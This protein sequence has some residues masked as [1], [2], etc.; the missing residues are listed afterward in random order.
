MEAVIGAVGAALGDISPTG[1][2]ESIRLDGDTVKVVVNT[3]EQQLP[4]S[5]T[6]MEPSSY[7]R[8]GCLILCDEERLSCKLS[9]ASERFQDAAALSAVLAKICQLLD[10]PIDEDALRAADGKPNDGTGMEQDG[11]DEAMSEDGSGYAD[12]DDD[13]DDYGG[14]DEDEQE[15]KELLVE[16]GQR[17]GRWARH[18]EELER[19]CSSAQVLSMEQ[20]KASRQQIFSS[21]EGFNM[22]QN[23]LLGFIRRQYSGAMH[24]SADSVGDDVYTWSVEMWKS[25]FRPD[26]QLAK[27]LQEVSAK[28]AVSSIQLRFSFMRGLHP[29]YPPR[30][31]VVRPHL[32]A[33][34]PGA[35]AS[36]P[37]LTLDHWD[38]CMNMSQLLERIKEFLE[39]WGSVDVGH[40][41]NSTAAHPDSA[42][43]PVQVALARLE[44]LTD[45][46]PAAYYQH[47]DLYEA[48]STRGRSDTPTDPPQQMKKQK[49]D[50]AA[51]AAAA[52]AAGAAAAAAAPAAAAG[53]AAGAGAAAAGAPGQAVVWAKGT[54]YGYGASRAPGNL[55]DPKKAAAAQEAQDEQLCGL[56]QGLAAALNEELGGCPEAADAA[57]AA[58]QPSSSSSAAAAA[59]AADS[60]PMDVGLSPRQQECLAAVQGSVL[61]PLLVREFGQVAFPE[62]VSR[63]QYFRPLLDVLA[64]LCRPATE[65]M[66]AAHALAVP[67]QQQQAAAGSSQQQQQQQQQV[68]I[69][70][71]LRGLIKGATMYRER[72]AKTLQSH[73]KDAGKQASSSAVPPRVDKQ[74]EALL[75][76]A[77]RSME[78]ADQLLSIT[79]KLQH[80]TT[81]EEVA[82]A[83]AAAGDAGGSG[84]AAAAAAQRGGRTRRA[85]RSS[86]AAAVAAAEAPQQQQ[87][88]APAGAGG[89]SSSSA[90]YE[91]ALKGLVL[92]GAPLASRH[93][94][95]DEASKDPTG[96]K[97]RVQKV[98]SEMAGIERLIDV[99][100][101]SS[102]FVRV[103]DDNTFLWKALITGPEDTPYGGGC[104]VFDMFFPPNYPNAPP[105][106][107][108]VTTGNGSV[109]FNP[110]LYN[111]GKVCLSLLGTWNGGQGEGWN[112]DV[113]SAFQVLVS[114]QSLILVPEPYFNEPGYEQRGTSQQ[115][116]EYNKVIREATIRWAMIDQLRNPPAEFAA[117]IR[118]H[119]KLQGPA[120]L[121]QVQ[122]WI[123]EAGGS[124][125]NNLKALKGQLETELAKLA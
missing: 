9:A 26:C 76:E 59:A 100:P 99:S 87:G 115:S 67:L 72:M 43:S 7:P 15:D 66:L 44:A 91:A 5:I 106:V 68:S 114:I 123:D 46:K 88:A 113:S 1:Q 62:M 94:F 103:D 36:H 17:Q 58:G 83:A 75:A 45:V 69:V 51:P 39:E 24:V 41:G 90:A 65:Q 50:E 121:G 56:L 64:A 89:S 95:R 74:T 40:P 28:W 79:T 63:P 119:F 20:G 96:L 13:D 92:D 8:S 52:P 101:A 47:A 108:L 19:S 33:P 102:I 104:F 32:A 82:A 25:A 22:L 120:V 80:L 124:H 12:D 93:K 73:E 116:K 34:L 31:E 77:K 105:K 38:S 70:G 23:E 27:D 122:G 61:L 60:D 78:I 16:C 53:A 71:A 11:S 21:K 3:G 57:A 30:L 2:L 86:A 85:T 84:A 35:L 6:Y 117:V 97:A 49:T 107:N 29:F 14:G 125:A 4:V 112:P 37:L 10:I 109:R 55:W 54:G 48:R 110:N 18:E 81:A 111:C 42:F 98:T 118:S